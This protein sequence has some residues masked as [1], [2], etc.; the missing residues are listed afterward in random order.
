MTGIRNSSVNLDG[1]PK[2]MVRHKFLWV[3]SMAIL[4]AVPPLAHACTVPVFRYALDNWHGTAD[5]NDPVGDSPVLKDFA[6]RMLAGDSAV[7]IQIDSGNKEV[8]DGMFERLEARLRFFESVA[9]LPEIDPND[10]SSRL[11]PGPELALKFSTIRIERDNPIVR[12]LVG[13]KADTLPDGE[14]WVA[15]VFGRGRVLGIWPSSR[16]DEEGIDEVCFYLTGACSCQV[17]AQN[18][19]WDLVVNVD[20]DRRLLAVS[21]EGETAV[22]EHSSDLIPDS[23]PST[24]SNSEPVTEEVKIDPAALVRPATVDI[25]LT[26]YLIAGAL[27]GLASMLIFRK[28]PTKS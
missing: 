25:N 13:A 5:R 24:E 4:F 10:P 11:G 21:E 28:R 1:N 9:E 19:G 20:W 14:A 2:G 7:W 23:P 3:V 8:D 15:P 27:L 17:K 16:M 12:E 26:P 6:N 18:P 22:P